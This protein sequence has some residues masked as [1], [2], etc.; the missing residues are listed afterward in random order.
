MEHDAPTDSIL[1][2]SVAYIDISQQK[3]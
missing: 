3:H 2:S 1:V